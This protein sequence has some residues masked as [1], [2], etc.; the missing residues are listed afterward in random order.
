MATRKKRSSAARPRRSY[1]AAPRRRG[2]RTKS[3]VTQIP[4][5]AATVGVAIANKDAVMNVI[6]APS[7][8]SVKQS[9]R[10]ALQPE[11]IKKDVIYGG[12]GLVAGAAI[13]KF[14]PR[15]LK[16]PMGKIAKKI[17]KFF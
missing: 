3:G 2:R 9:V 17:P 13:K 15:A 14:A 11:Q 7:V 10:Y 4:A 16:T 12:V 5:A 6:N 1:Y 8:E